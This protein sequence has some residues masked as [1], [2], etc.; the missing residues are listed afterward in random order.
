MKKL[1]LIGFLL[2]I[3]TGICFS[4]AAGSTMYV[5]VKT[6]DLKN[7]TGFFAGKVE[8]LKQG[9]AVTVVSVNGKW[10]QVRSPARLT[11]WAQSDNFSSRVVVASGSAT[12]KEVALAGKGFSAETE[13]E[14]R[15]EGLDYSQVDAMERTVVPLADLEKFVKDG[16]LK[17]GK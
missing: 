12:A 4:Q 17:E 5:A 1:V 15:K 7:G 2:V 3:V 16:R 8:T 13:I 9:D 11:G 10:L 14:Y 6:I